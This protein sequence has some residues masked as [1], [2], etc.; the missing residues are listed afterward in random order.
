M[1]HRV[2]KTPYAAFYVMYFY[3]DQSIAFLIAAISSS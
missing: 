2:L 1:L 3:T